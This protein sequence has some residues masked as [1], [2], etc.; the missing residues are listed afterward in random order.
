M[1]YLIGAIIVI[2]LVYLLVVYV[3]APIAGALG[4]IALAIGAGYALVVSIMSFA[5][6]LKAH[7]DPYTT[8]IDK[9][10]KAT[11]GTKRNYFFGPGYHQIGIT[12]KDAFINQASYIKK[13]TKWWKDFRLGHEWILNIWVTIFYVAACICMYVFGTIWTVLFSTLLFVVIFIGMCGFYL[14]FS[15]LWLTDRITLMLR[16]I[17]SRCPNCKRISIVPVFCCPDCGAQHKNLTPGPYGVFYQT[18]VCGR[19]LPTTVFN[20]RSELDAMC[21]Y[22]PTSLAASDAKQFGIQLV[23]GVSTG[24]TTFLAS[25]WHAYIEQLQNDKS[26][27]FTCFPQ[28]AFDNLEY[29]YQRGISEATNETNATMYSILH[30]RNGSSPVQMTIY[31]VA[32]ESFTNLSSDIQQQQFKY[33]EGIIIVVDPTASAETN[34]GTISAFVNEFKQLR[35]IRSSHLSQIPVA[36]VISKADLFKREI[37]VTKIKSLYNQALQT[38][39]S[40]NIELRDVRN[41]TCK[42]F[43][44]MHG[45]DNIVN[46]VDSEFERTQYFPISAIGHEPEDSVPYE[47]WGV[48]DPVLWIM[49]QAKFQP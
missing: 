6:S 27:E 9:N 25:Y 44:C 46:M 36:V 11:P 34:I 48:I 42:D 29:W 35:G 16:S 17:Q 28:E 4:A 15:A 38:S 41:N 37:G 7:I 24:K 39:P 26:L 3:I 23:G 13:I 31:D 19:E 8:Y 2:I 45:F 12:V 21:P 1:G 10:P 49:K 18:C 32:G 20:K 22:C 33:C 30:K 40:A 47:P 5:S 14:F 43:L